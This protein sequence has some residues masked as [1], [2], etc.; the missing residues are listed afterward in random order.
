VNEKHNRKE[1]DR[2]GKRK[3]EVEEAARK[4]KSQLRREKGR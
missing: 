2:K 4:G 1:A 3:L